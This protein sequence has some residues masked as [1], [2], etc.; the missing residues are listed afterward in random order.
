MGG[1]LQSVPAEGP[2]SAEMIDVVIEMSVHS[3]FGVTA[4]T[5]GFVF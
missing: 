1:L 5:E 2:L 3:I 4:D